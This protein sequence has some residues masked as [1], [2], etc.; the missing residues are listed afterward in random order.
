MILWILGDRSKNEF[1]VLSHQ[2]FYFKDKCLIEKVVIHAPFRFKV[3]FHDEACFIY[4]LEGVA[5][6]NSP[7]EQVGVEQEGAMLLR[8]G[9]YFADLVEYGTAS[10]YDVLVFHLYPG[11]LR[12]IYRNEIPG[13]VKPSEKRIFIH[14]VASHDIIRKF[15]ESLI[16]YFQHP[17][18]V[19][20]DL[21][22]LKIKELVLLLIQTESAAS[23]LELFADLFTPRVLSVREVVNN[24]LFS[25]ISIADM[26]GLVNMSLSTFNRTFLELFN[27]T[28]ASYIKA[29]RLERARELLAVSALS[30]SEIAFQTCFRDMGHFSRSFKAVYR[31]SPTAYR[32]SIQKEER[33]PG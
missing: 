4:F 25:D 2:K 29:K 9:S 12:E 6:V 3:D 28:P 24:H 21:L 8:C 19:N 20:D 5:R 17:T 31:C 23:V 26:A 7:H 30:I 18:V 16:F 1:M 32:L 14:K 15:I 11:I 10:R 33:Y 22:E 27:D 13:F